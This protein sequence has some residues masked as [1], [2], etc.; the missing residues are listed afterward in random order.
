MRKYMRKANWIRN[1]IDGCLNQ[2]SGQLR[3]PT[4]P[5]ESEFELID[6][7]PQAGTGYLM[8]SAWQTAFQI[9][10]YNARGR[11]QIVDFLNR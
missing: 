5:I 4:A 3:F 1:M 8:A 2:A 7:F 10:N 11:Q 6:V 9:G